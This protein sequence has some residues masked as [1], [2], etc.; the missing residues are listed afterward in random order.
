MVLV[1][2]DAGVGKTRFAGEGMARAA[3]AGMVMVRGECLPLAG[4]LPLLPVAQALR[5]L[6]E[7]TGGRRLEEAL[8]AAPAY[9][10]GEVG[11]LLPQVGPGGGPDAGGRD[12]GWRRERLFSAVADLLGAV[13]GESGA[14][15]VVED[16]HWADRTTL[17]FLTFL[18][19][20]G[21]RG[22][23]TVVVTCR[24]DEAPLAA[25]VAGWLAQV[26]G[27]AGVEE[28][29][30]GP[31]SRVETAEQV[32]ALAGGPVPPGVVDEVFARAEGNPFFTEQLVAA[33]LAG[34]DGGTLPV[35][36]GLPAR[37]AELLVARAG[38]C[39]ESGRV[40]LAG[41]AVAG[42]PLPEDLASEVTGLEP[43]EVRRGLRE[44]AAAR[45]LAEG[46]PGGGHRPRHALLAEAVAA[47][48]LP[49]ERVELHERTAH[50]LRGTGDQA[51]AAEAAGHWQAAGR[52]AEELPARVAAAEAAE[53][54]FGYAEAARHWQRAVELGQAL[55]GAAEA[56]GIGL[57]RMFVRAIDA[58]QA[59]GGGERAG[60]LA[61]EAYRRYAGHD[62][63][64]TAAVICARAAYFRHIEAPDAG[65]PLMKEA[66]RLFGQAGPSAEHARAWLDYTVIS[67]A[68]GRL[69]PATTALTAALKIAEAVGA[70]AMIPQIL[71]LLAADAFIRRRP[72][73]GFAFL[74]RA[75]ALAEAS[76]AA[77]SQLWQDVTESDVLLKTGDFTRAAGLALRGLQAT[78]QTG[79]FASVLAANAAEALLALGRTA[80]AAAVIDPRTTG[81]PDRDHWLVH[82]S[83]AEIDLLRGESGAAAERWQQLTAITGSLGD[84]DSAR[85]AA[86]RAAE[87]ALWAGRP[88]D[89]LAEVQRVIALFP[90]PDLTIFCGRLLATGMRACADLAEKAR[91][92]R[93]DHAASAAQAAADNLISWV[94]QMAG[95]PFADHPFL[96]TI[97]AERATWDA[98]L[99]R[100][101]GAS[102][103]A[104]WSA[105]AKTWEGLGCPHLAGYAWWRGAEAQLNAGLTRTATTTLRAAAAAADGHAPL[106]AQI[107][108]LA[109][110]ARI[111]LHPPPD[112]VT[113]VPPPD[114]AVPYGLTGRELAVLGLVAAGRTNAQIGAELYI[115]PK[116]AS[117]HVTSILRKL[118][119][120]GRA[121][122]A[123]V[124]ERAGLLRDQ[125]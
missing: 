33:A 81:P 59:S 115:S 123:A 70:T 76:G 124:A 15:L 60:E 49:A 44:L 94:D 24:S 67:F 121:Q 83:R 4:T 90:A 79:S 40:V 116:T 42:R 21:R 104:A 78:R 65:L 57:P 56:A 8:T 34:P 74:R 47:A 107:R 53:R 55:P 97:P 92:R 31:L 103:P 32:A 98:E 122:A 11:R 13:A 117:V 37:L 16:V 58:L 2:G 105:A 10:R 54:V 29:T 102:D 3:A 71:A 41:L 51:L 20:L 23:V 96:A 43:A 17:D 75:R 114:A 27:A 14:G 85:E 84:I 52:P 80:E 109:Q 64:G 39:G 99:T 86:Q 108:A 125:G 1:V 87:L 30:L 89:A 93:D 22:A 69:Q 113:R 77:Q 19:R 25:P 95:T 82:A 111:P 119:V 106:L 18:A 5:E 50:A 35:P 112:A 28:I 63:P 61:E 7:P 62:D 9:V 100:L 68:Q 66:L 26:R 73:E 48:L 91:A 6:G 45:L 46:T 12:G 36:A 120:S 118:G 110:R 88:A 38:R 72:G 101:A